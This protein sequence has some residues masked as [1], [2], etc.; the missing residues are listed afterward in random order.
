MMTDGT[1][2]NRP[3]QDRKTAGLELRVPL[4]RV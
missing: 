1:G 2:E 3:L 4:T